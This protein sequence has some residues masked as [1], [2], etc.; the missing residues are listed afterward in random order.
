MWR[1]VAPVVAMMG[2]VAVG[3]TACGGPTKTVT[4]TVTVTTTVT[5]T[6]SAAAVAVSAPAGASAP[7]SAA[8]SLPTA[9]D[10]CV[11]LTLNE[12]STLAGTKLQAGTEAG[13]GGEKTL[14]QYTGDPN[15]PTAQVEI[16][17]G[18]GAKKALD[19]DRDNLGH[20][21]TN[22]S[23]IGDEAAQE[24]DAIFVRKGTTWIEINLVLLNDA[25]QNVQP[26]QTAAKLAAS[27][28]P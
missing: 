14:C 21:F 6:P 15:G 10:P 3:A 19:I 28:L 8:A 23:G 2:A 13:A 17:V 26:M 11:L 16:F 5:A 7:A 12:A 24:D 25:A 18:D 4:A 22:V 27:R 9:P 20:T 1:T